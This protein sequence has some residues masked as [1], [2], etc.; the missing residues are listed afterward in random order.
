MDQDSTVLGA[1]YTEQKDN[2]CPEEF[3]I[4]IQDYLPLQF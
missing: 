2:L 1:V 4:Y 3:A